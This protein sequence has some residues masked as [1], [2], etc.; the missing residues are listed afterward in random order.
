M[1]IVLF[2]VIH[3]YLS[4]FFQS[5]FHHRYAAHAHFTMTKGWEKVFNI[6]CFITQGSSYIS[7]YSYGVM[8]R[9]HHQHAD[10]IDDPHSPANHPNFFRMMFE[11]R[12]SYHNIYT[13]KTIIDDKIKKGLPEWKAFDKIAH[14]WVTRVCWIAIYTSIYIIFA[15]AWWQY[16]LLPLTT[17]MGTLHG[18][19]INWGAHKFGYVNF[20]VNDTSTNLLPCDILLWGE[21]YHNNHHK[22]PGRPSY[23]H[24]W[25]EFD[26]T[27]AVIR[28][29][30]KMNIVQLKKNISL[31]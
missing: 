7:A 19:I 8:H 17:I 20:P 12:N 6:C 4:L 16:L 30:N 18:A 28:V 31:Q 2:F 10:T 21:A 14:N 29:L 1:I 25:F 11:T 9:L 3:W 24:R 26:A 5:F 27:Y 23:A 22:Y 13:Q 15:T